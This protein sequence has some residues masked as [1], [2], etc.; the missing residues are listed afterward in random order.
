MR[1]G[2][3]GGGGGGGICHFH[4]PSFR[5]ISHL[6]MGNQLFSQRASKA[7]VKFARF[8]HPGHKG[9]PDHGPINALLE[10][11]GPGPNVD[12]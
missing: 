2:G 7:K 9:S 12:G 6:Y 8:L 5:S 1:G 3:G 10:I 11:P 4:F